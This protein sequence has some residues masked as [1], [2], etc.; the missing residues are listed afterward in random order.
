M[1]YS[2]RG[3]VI[4]D[5][6]KFKSQLDSMKSSIDSLKGLNQ[7]TGFADGLFQKLESIKNEL[8]IINDTTSSNEAHFRQ[9]KNTV[10]EVVLSIDELKNSV[11]RM[12]VETEES[13]ELEERL[14]ELEYKLSREKRK[15]REERRKYKADLEEELH[16]EKEIN[17]ENNKRKTSLWDRFLGRGGKQSSD[18]E[19]IVESLAVIAQATAKTNE[20]LQEQAEYTNRERDYVQEINDLIAQENAEREKSKRLTAEEQRELETVANIQ[21]RITELKKGENV[22]NREDVTRQTREE[23]RELTRFGNL[24]RR[25][26]LDINKY[27]PLEVQNQI[28]DLDKLSKKI[29]ELESDLSELLTFEEAFG[30]GEMTNEALNNELRVQKQL[31]TEVKNELKTLYSEEEINTQGSSNRINALNNRLKELRANISEIMSKLMSSAGGGTLSGSL[32]NEINELK[33]KYDKAYSELPNIKISKAGFGGMSKQLEVILERVAILRTRLKE[34]KSVDYS[35]SP[36]KIE[37]RALKIKIY[38]EQIIEQLKIAKPLLDILDVDFDKLVQDMTL[39][40]D[41]TKEEASLVKELITLE[42]E[43]FRVIEKAYS[44]SNKNVNIRKALNAEQ[45]EGLTLAKASSQQLMTDY[46]RTTGV[47][48]YR[49]QINEDIQRFGNLREAMEKLNTM[50]FSNSSLDYVSR[51]WKSVKATAEEMISIL[52]EHED[53]LS[54]MGYDIE[55]IGTK[56]GEL[57]TSVN[58]KL[59]NAFGDKLVDNVAKAAVEMEKL[60][61]EEA[62]IT[63]LKDAE[64]KKSEQV[65]TEIEKQIENVTKLK[66]RRKELNDMI[67]GTGDYTHTKHKP[68]KVG[69]GKASDYYNDVTGESGFEM[70]WRPN[71]DALDKTYVSVEKLKEAEKELVIINKELAES[72][73]KLGE[74]GYNNP[75]IASEADMEKAL[76]Y[77]REKISESL[78]HEKEKVTALMSEYKLL[79][80]SVLNMT[81]AGADENARSR[82]LD[83]L[84]NKTKELEAAFESLIPLFEKYESVGGELTAEET[85][86]I[87]TSKK[88]VTTNKELANSIKLLNNVFNQEKGELVSLDVEYN[89]NY[90][91][92]QKQNLIRQREIS[93]INEELSQYTR[94]NTMIAESSRKVNT[95]SSSTMSASQIVRLSTNHNANF[96]DSLNKIGNSAKVTEFRMH[97]IMDTIYMFKNVGR[98]I[99]SLVIWD[100]GFKL[101]EVSSETTK[102]KSE[103]E[104]FQRVLHMTSAESKSFNSSLDATIK[105]FPKMNKYN[106]GET[107]ASLGVEFGLTS[108]EMEKALPV[109][110]MI[111]NEYLRAGRTMDEAVLAVKDVSQGEFQRLSR[112]TGVG[113][114]ELKAAGWNGVTNTS[115]GLLSLY[116]AL[117]KIGTSRHWDVIAQKATSINDIMT[118]S[119]NRFGEFTTFLSDLVTPVVVGGFNLMTDGITGLT[120]ILKESPDTSFIATLSSSILLIKP[121][122]SSTKILSS[123]LKELATVRIAHILDL[124][125]ETMKLKGFSGALAEAISKEELEASM[126]NKNIETS[127]KAILNR[128]IEERA[129]MRSNYFK[130]IEQKTDEEKIALLTR[131]NQGTTESISLRET[132]NLTD[133]Q[134]VAI[135]EELNNSL[136]RLSTTE[137]EEMAIREKSLSK[138]AE[139]NLLAEETSLIMGETEVALEKEAIMRAGVTDSVVAEGL[140]VQTLTT[141]EQT[142]LEMGEARRIV[143]RQYKLEQLSTTQALLMHT[144]GLDANAVAE[145]GVTAGIY[146]HILGL[147]GEEAAL[148]ATEFANAGLLKK[149]KMMVTSLASVSAGTWVAVGAIAALAA[150]LVSVYLATAQ[151]RSEMREFN[152]VLDEGDQAVTDLSERTTSYDNQL[153]QLN[154]TR[155]E[156]LKKGLDTTKLDKEEVRLTKLKT[157]ATKEEEKARKRL[158]QYKDVA[159]YMEGQVDYNHS[160]FEQQFEEQLRSKGLLSPTEEALLDSG[161]DLTLQ[162][163]QARMQK[164]VDIYKYNLTD[165][166][167]RIKKHRKELV[168]EG[169]SGDE[170]EEQLTSMKGGEEWFAQSYYDYLVSDDFFDQLKSIGGMIGASVSEGLQTGDWT[171]FDK[172]V[173]TAGKG[174]ESIDWESFGE[175]IV[176]GAMHIP[177]GD[178]VGGFFKGSADLVGGVIEGVGKAIFGEDA[179]NE[180]FDKADKRKKEYEDKAK[181]D[182][183]MLPLAFTMWWDDIANAPSILELLFPEPVSAAD[184]EGKILPPTFEEDLRNLFDFSRFG[185]DPLAWFNTSI[186]PKI[187]TIIYWLTPSNWFTVGQD[188]ATGMIEWWN[189]SVTQPISNWY[190]INL[191]PTIDS[192]RYWLNPSHWW[193]AVADTGL[194]ILGFL[195]NSIITPIS[196]WYKNTLKPVVDKVKFYSNPAN[197]FKDYEASGKQ[198]GGGKSSGNGNGENQGLANQLNTMY[199]Q[200]RNAHPILHRLSKTGAGKIV[201]G[202][203]Q[204]VGAHVPAK[205]EMEDVYRS[206]VNKTGPIW[207]K[208]LEMAKG[209]VD[210][211][212]EGLNRHS[213]GDAAKTVLSEFTDMGMFINQQTPVL[214]T[215]AQNAGSAIVN[216]V[217]TMNLSS[218]VDFN[219]LAQDMGSAQNQTGALTTAY[220]N[221][222]MTVSGTLGTINTQSQNT[223]NTLGVN[224]A[225]AFGTMG[226][227]ATDGM[228]K[229]KTNVEVGFNNSQKVTNNNLKSMQSTTVSTTQRMVSAWNTM[230]A[231]IVNSATKIRNQSY[232]KFSSLNRT[233]GNF[234]NNLKNATFSSGLSM[235][236]R[237]NSYNNYRGRRV[238]V[239]S[240]KPN[241]GRIRFGGGSRTT[242][243]PH[244]DSYGPRDKS[245]E[246]LKLLSEGNQEKLKAFHLNN[247][248]CIGDDCYYGTVS[249]NYNKILHSAYPWTL[250]K[251]GWHGYEVGSAA[252]F[253]KSVRE[254]DMGDN[255]KISWSQF[256]PVLT[257]LISQHGID[258]EYY[259]N[260]KRS[261]Q[262]VWNDHKCNCWDGAELLVELGKEMGFSANMVHG[263]WKGEGHMGAM[264]NGKLFD[265]TQFSKHGVWRGTPGVHFGSSPSRRHYGGSD[266]KTVNNKKV[267][268]VHVHMENSQIYGVDDLDKRIKDSAHEVALEYLDENPSTGW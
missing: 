260:G 164:A 118:I 107:V 158:Q 82:M 190:T 140:A 87:E 171:N 212:K 6:S 138:I 149:L 134:R 211:I 3:T 68:F 218:P 137:L 241:G 43:E 71:K 215:A 78:T 201:S 50:D 123:Q 154:K 16:V 262:Q 77:T 122:I 11:E 4:L 261:N 173:E 245:K 2:I 213:P 99:G 57:I 144:L 48:N 92:I 225:K 179:V 236:Y 125:D 106:L 41:K 30:K 208:A 65:N 69:G 90:E 31:I 210:K 217:R 222:G 98:M 193:T 139:E 79:N 244:S 166:M 12:N 228:N 10:S 204:V 248:D 264:I 192:I 206:I 198:E 183:P 124:S 203:G 182:P 257:S 9:M 132:E 268:N 46:G 17:N 70:Y 136:R 202:L 266:N 160:I 109:V 168:K 105:R 13:I 14:E 135:T 147:K 85:K 42:N 47:R 229:M 220:S 24:N 58:T 26:R 243:R 187:D 214:Q 178:I 151:G 232:S 32:R 114:E 52:R 28:R 115:E 143:L 199:T 95:F 157:K 86:L 53:V 22:L 219:A 113:K 131:L 130:Q 96:S 146:A 175:R 103:M 39:A 128:Q 33:L 188:T 170:I 172:L 224:T 238:Y 142:N 242:K 267:V 127:Y 112:E 1:D 258:Y 62:N 51:T 102:A 29:N 80:S 227:T 88:F 44:A 234:Y 75:E 93:S 174:F 194:G 23:M 247:G 253:S 246:Y 250:N 111:T 25:N 209:I 120:N 186:K 163:A 81:K 216:G 185:I 110:S 66:A 231:N 176:E 60:T 235:G 21:R 61:G 27:R 256:E 155:E 121:L 150:A 196:N 59:D 5:T 191:K 230:R 101:L 181:K 239:G 263:D 148:K 195:N 251:L 152:K 72:V 73:L 255:K 126:R 240:T 237:P 162:K 116:E 91:G 159:N 165:A 20:L 49:N 205:L 156:Y 119:Q 184:V 15:N 84:R 189:T 34:L 7:S 54:L 197:W 117:N 265:M 38:T 249:K 97:K 226:V 18:I 19:L 64:I 221:M 259:A 177:V 167:E 67:N 169:L 63:Q 104:S 129:L 45:K 100:M 141:Y 83:K 76:T 207:N 56:T 8:E 252:N 89:R 36:V 133:S 254:F 94:L 200:L 55:E 161:T 153:K 74:Y 35:S 108:E 37:E 40:N 223:F 180:Y 145:G 233:I